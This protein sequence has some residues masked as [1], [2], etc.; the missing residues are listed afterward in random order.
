MAGLFLGALVNVIDLDSP[1]LGNTVAA[2]LEGSGAG[3]VDNGAHSY[4]IVV[5]K[6]DATHTLP[7]GAC[8]AV[9][10]VD[11]T[12]NGMVLVTRTGV[13]P[14]GDTWDF[15]RTIANAD[16]VTAIYSLVNPS[17][18][19][20][21]STWYIDN[22]ADGSLGAA[23]PLTST[24][25]GT[26]PETV[27]VTA[28]TGSTFTATFAR[29]H[30]AN[31]MFNAAAPVYW[32]DCEIDLEWNSIRWLAKPITPGPVSNQPDGMS[33][34]FTFADS[35]DALF[36]VLNTQSG[37][38]LAL[39]AIYEAGF[40]LT[41]KSAVPDEV[42]EIFSGRVDRATIDAQD[43]VTFVLMPPVMMAAGQLPTRLIS[44]LLRS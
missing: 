9:T 44:T 28:V 30:S 25:V 1:A 38:E 43:I 36:V 26:N 23:A 40:L 39:A 29:A 10:V 35:D 19:A 2:A 16:P 4:K 41:T 11:K 12:T 32:T 21:S 13:V 17:P 37:G 42:I 3:N 15:Y 27:T 8:P 33:A 20:A 24:T 7:S 6:T 22:I 5:N 14:T 18:I 34:T 31:W